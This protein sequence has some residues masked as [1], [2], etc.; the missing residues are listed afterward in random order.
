[1][2]SYVARQAILD[3]DKEL[4]GYEL[5]F[6]NGKNNCYPDVEPDE[7]TSKLLVENHLSLG[8]DEITDSNRAFINFYEDTLLYRFPT[9]L[10]P[11]ITVI[12]ILEYVPISE[13]LLD[14]CKSIKEQGY[15]IAL[16]DHDFDPK[17]DVFLPY[18][19][20]IKIDVR[21]H[22]VDTIRTNI[23]K[24]IDAGTTL[25]AEKV[26]TMEEFEIFSDMGFH[27]FQGY[28]FSKPEIVKTRKIPPSKLNL[29][30]LIGA[31]ASK[32][33]NFDDVNSIIERDVSLSYKLLRFINS[34]LNNKSNKIGSLHHALVYMGELEL[35]K[36]IS[37][38]SLA[39]MGDS[40]PSEL[41]VLCLS[42]AKFCELI[43][44]FRREDENPPKG[45]LTGLFSMM[46]AV[47]DD[48]MESLVERLPLLP[49]IKT[50]LTQRK[51]SL[52]WYLVL[53]ELYEKGDWKK[54]NKIAERL[55][56]PVETMDE[57]YTESV[58]WSNKL[59]HIN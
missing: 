10:D 8:I 13:E 57:F 30:Q 3:R 16:D 9:S 58:Q 43:A 53:V 21:D 55:K 42:R 54:V 59:R 20:I 4:F 26:E 38:M 2:Y 28:F 1:M 12:E 5:L 15:T 18:T 36:F 35:K 46:D 6:R 41:M 45:F 29:I 7:A 27:L 50:A 51:G 48:R 39:N 14:A 34:P 52:G 25:V 24:Y 32:E 19:D 11:E 44:R 37:L 40:K 23:Q 47:L 17:W 33:M 56:I 31:S 22:S 49:E